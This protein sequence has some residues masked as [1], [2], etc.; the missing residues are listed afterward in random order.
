[1]KS[2][3]ARTFCY[4]LT[5]YLVTALLFLAFNISVSETS[6]TEQYIVQANAWGEANLY[7]FFENVDIIELIMVYVLTICCVDLVFANRFFINNKAEEVAVRLVCG[8]TFTQLAFYVL[9]QTGLL[10]LAA[11]PLGILTALA[12]MPVL[13]NYLA[14]TLANPFTIYVSSEAITNFT[15][16]IFMI[17]LW[18]TILNLSFAYLNEAN[19]ILNGSSTTRQKNNSLLGGL[20]AK[21][22][23]VFK[24]AAGIALVVFSIMMIFGSP[25]GCIVYGIT[26]L[27][28]IELA[29]QFALIPAMTWYED[30]AGLRKPARTIVLSFVREDLRA[31]KVGVYLLIGNA[32]TLIGL[33]VM[34]AGSDRETVM[35]LLTYV[36]MNVM[37]AMAL[38]FR[39]QTH[40][41]TRS[42]EYNVLA[43]VGYEPSEQYSILRKEMALFFLF[44]LAFTALIMGCTLYALTNA[45]IL[46]VG[47]LPVLILTVLICIAVIWV[48]SVYAYKN[49]AHIQDMIHSVEESRR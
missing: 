34:R 24:G 48:L 43:Q 49:S 35:I 15:I 28:G 44:I 2:D 13:N 46:S 41:S 32:V 27:V 11:L 7:T 47:K 5:F 4:F 23:T 33:L 42:S 21:I 26:A 6:V 30:H 10:I 31:V 8:A 45:S 3:P 16:I 1:M 38:M 9:I 20:L 14:A 17:I 19:A 29:I 40:L 22:P 36:V 12:A 37:Q 18:C 25:K 39:L